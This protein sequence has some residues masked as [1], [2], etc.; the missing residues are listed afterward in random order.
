MQPTNSTQLSLLNRAKQA[1]QNNPTRT[2]AIGIGAVIL[3]PALVPLVKPLAKATIKG[4]VSL[5]EKTKGAIAETS[6][7]L[8]DLVAEAKAEVAA[9]QIQKA[10]LNAELLAPQNA[11]TPPEN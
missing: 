2:I 1:Y 7:A 9:E 4:G 10:S 3:V 8:G 11:Q 6:E 5:Y